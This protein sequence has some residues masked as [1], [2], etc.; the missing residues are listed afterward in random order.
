VEDTPQKPL[1]SQKEVSTP[2]SFHSLDKLIANYE[3]S[4]NEQAK[5]MERIQRE[6]AEIKIQSPPPMTP[7]KPSTSRVD[8]EREEK[9][10]TPLLFG[11][12]LSKQLE[13][14]IKSIKKEAM[15]HIE[16]TTETNVQDSPPLDDSTSTEQ[17]AA[18]EAKTDN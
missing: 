4:M 7:A 8:A 18:D 15:K 12:E 1:D 5:E 16:S 17:S 3:Q 10:T 6:V 2:V 14:K 11:D 9:T 13:E